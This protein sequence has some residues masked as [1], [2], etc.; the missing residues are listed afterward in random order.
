MNSLCV[1]IAR[2]LRFHRQMYVL[3]FEGETFALMWRSKSRRI[4][5]VK[6]VE[7]VKQRERYVCVY[8]YIYTVVYMDTA[9]AFLQAPL[10]V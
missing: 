6:P 7:R 9:C 10:M 5:T 8:T 3:V 2:K 4:R 1:S